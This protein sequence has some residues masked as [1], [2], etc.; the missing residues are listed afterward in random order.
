MFFKVFS[1]FPSR[2]NATCPE[3]QQVSYEYFDFV[4]ILTLCWVNVVQ[5]V[6]FVSTVIPCRAEV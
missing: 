3:V 5:P 6:I 1:F 2:V 4:C